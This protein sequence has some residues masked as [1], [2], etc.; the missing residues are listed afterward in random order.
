MPS[1]PLCF[2]HVTSNEGTRRQTQLPPHRLLNAEHVLAVA[3][4]SS[5]LCLPRVETTLGKALGKPRNSQ[6]LHFVTAVGV[7]VELGPGL[8]V[9][10][11]QFK[12]VTPSKNYPSPL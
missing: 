2:T 9:N 11:I 4:V 10:Y 5:R 7:A 8:N 3:I 12:D 6:W 1:F